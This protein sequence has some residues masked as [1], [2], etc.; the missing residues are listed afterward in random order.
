MASMKQALVLCAGK[1]R[2]LTPYSQALPKMCM[3][4]LNLPLLSFSWFYLEKL[5]VSRFLLNTHLFPE[6]LEKRVNFLAQPTQEKHYFF[7]EKPL[8]GAGALYHLKQ[9]LQK[10]ESFFYI[11]GDSL[12]FPSHLHKLS[13]FVEDFVKTGLDASFFV[14]PLP[15]QNPD[16][17]SLWCDKELNLR[18]VGTKAQLKEESKNLKPFHF[19]GLAFFRSSLLDNLN[20][21]AYSLFEDLINPLLGQ[22]Q[23][24]VFLDEEALILEAGLKASYIES[25]KFCLQALFSEEDSGVKDIL[26]KIFFRFDPKDHLVGLANGKKWSQKLGHPLLAPKSVKGLE[27]LKLKDCAVLGSNVHLFGPSQIKDSVL[28]PEI[29]WKGSLENEILLKFGK[30]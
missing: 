19:S 30:F 27:N 18:F 10:E 6:Q 21:Q 9:E 28:G 3:P 8:G 24:K 20:G 5:G 14:S 1:A 29:S 17:G 12:F 16:M 4:F 15:A 13:E 2:R 23:I 25:L 7:E 22:K 26:K 11:N